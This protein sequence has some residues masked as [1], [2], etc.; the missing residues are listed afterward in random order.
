MRALS[1]RGGRIL[2]YHRVVPDS[3]P[4]ILRQ[5]FGTTIGRHAFAAQIYHLQRHYRVV[6]LG[7]LLGHRERPDRMVAITF[8]DGY[9]DT[10]KHALPLLKA[11]EVPA[12]LFA[13][14]GFVGTGIRRW[15]DRL[16]RRVLHNGPEVLRF[17]TGKTCK[18]FAFQGC[19]HKQMKA[20]TIWLE[21]LPS[22]QRDALLGEQFRD[23]AD[24]FLDAHELKELEQE[25]VKI[26]AH[27]VR[28][29]SLSAL[30]QKAALKE[31]SQCKGMLESIVQRPVEFIAYPYGRATDFNH[32]TKEAALQAGFRAGFAAYRGLV[33]SGTD[34]FAI[35]R[36]ATC[37][38]LDRFKF[39]LTAWHGFT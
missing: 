34:L 29:V 36:I 13:I 24:R 10:L 38:D 7:E 23:D 30:T 19:Y 1:W 12:T 32:D 5:L 21:S 8:D 16:A 18:E 4:P 33:H 37:E 15:R 6:S 27:T 22:E 28:H 9:A 20:V 14:S 11:L 35:P 39:K 3:Y 26:E 2:L 17:D 31:L 25:G